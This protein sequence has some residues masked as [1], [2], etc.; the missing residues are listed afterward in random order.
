MA[1][2]HHFLT[3][4]DFEAYADGELAGPRR[5][6]VEASLARDPSKRARVAWLARANEALRAT[7]DAL[8]ANAALREEIER[9]KAARC[10]RRRLRA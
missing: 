1:N 2:L 4:R 6:A 8:Y 3:D 10:E 9:L 7:K 5:A